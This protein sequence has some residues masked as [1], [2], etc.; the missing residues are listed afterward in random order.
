M[1]INGDPEELGFWSKGCGPVTM[2]IAKKDVIWLTG[3]AVK[4]WDY[5]VSFKSEYCPEKLTYKYSVRNDDQDTTV[6]ER[7]PSRFLRI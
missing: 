6:W 2:G 7:E 5:H 1:R 3:E 4:P